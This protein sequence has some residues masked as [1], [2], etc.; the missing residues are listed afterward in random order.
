[1][2]PTCDGVLAHT[3][4]TTALSM[5]VCATT[6]WF[7]NSPHCSQD[8]LQP[9]MGTPTCQSHA[10]YF[11]YMAM[12]EICCSH[13][14]ACILFRR[15]LSITHITCFCIVS[16]IFDNTPTFGCMPCACTLFGIHAYMR[17]CIHPMHT[18]SCMGS[19]SCIHSCVHIHACMS[20]HA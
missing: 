20:M 15:P 11:A 10:S 16:H 3:G 2:C 12:H 19:Y 5:W 8:S 1:M 4:S 7:N 18:K 9:C 17:T 14:V 13:A 6:V